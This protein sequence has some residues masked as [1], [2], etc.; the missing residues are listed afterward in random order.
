MESDFEA[1]R[2][3]LAMLTLFSEKFSQGGHN[4]MRFTLG[5]LV[6]VTLTLIIT[7]YNL[8]QKSQIPSQTDTS[9]ENEG[10]ENSNEGSEKENSNDKLLL[11]V[12]QMFGLVYRAMSMYKQLPNV[13]LVCMQLLLYASSVALQ[14][15][16]L[17]EIAEEYIDTACEVYQTEVTSSHDQFKGVTQL[18]SHAL[19]MQAK[20]DYEIYKRVVLMCTQFSARLLIKADQCRAIYLCSHLFW[21]SNDLEKREDKKVL[22]CLQRA[23]K[24]ANAATGSQVLLFTEVLQKYLCFYELDCPVITLLH[25]QAMLDLIWEHVSS[26]DSSPEADIARR[27]FENTLNHIRYK[28]R[29]SKRQAKE[30]A[31][32][33]LAEEEEEKKLAEKTEIEVVKVTETTGGDDDSSSSDA[34]NPEGEGPA[35][36][37]ENSKNKKKSEPH[38]QGSVHVDKKNLKNVHV[39]VR[40]AGLRLFSEDEVAM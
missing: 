24:I 8:Y 7:T 35:S 20:L 1:C 23:V 30:A 22:A 10:S 16:N 39:N 37:L 19:H 13:G 3:K 28:K 17:Q 4:R 29:L 2:R 40:Y 31:L 15:C 25:I 38:D 36:E 6:S 18:V 34:G 33:Q 11:L 14:H 5:P 9:N 12:R 27:Y 21:S 26:L 32:R